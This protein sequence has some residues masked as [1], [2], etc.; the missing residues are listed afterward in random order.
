MDAARTRGQ[1][2]ALAAV[3]S[4]LAGSAPH[5]VLLAGPRGVGKTT[6]A[7]DLAAGLSCE[8]PDPADRPC[9]GCRGC[10]M[11]DHGNHPDVHRLG[12]AGPGDQIVIGGHGSRPAGVRDLVTALALLPVEGGARV[13]VIERA[14]RMNED[15]QT[16]LLKTLEEPPAGVTIVLCA[17]EEERLLPAVRSRCARVRLGP[18]RTRDIELILAEHGVADA[19]TAARLGRLSGGLPGVA[20]AYARA[21]DAIVIRTEIV[22]VLLDLLEARVSARLVAM[23]ELTARSAELVTSLD[24]SPRQPDGAR[25]QTG[26]RG[27]KPAAAPPSGALDAGDAGTDGDVGGDADESEGTKRAPASERRRAVGALIDVWTQVARDILVVGAGV[28]ESIRDVEGLEEVSTASSEVPAAAI[29]AFLDRL[30]VG[31]ERLEANVA[32][33][34]VLDGLVIEW[35][36]RARA[37]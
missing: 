18:V 14:D 21:P 7:L 24:A 17:D 25:S 3:R 23:R 32:P 6:L 9:R 30:A 4:M 5:A 8:A 19:P 12:P 36:R 13:A 28:P 22:R 35:P 2:A 11:V 27:K 20:L 33:E 10:R 37:A 31:R 16:A 15:A 1:P 26:P 34:L 29:R